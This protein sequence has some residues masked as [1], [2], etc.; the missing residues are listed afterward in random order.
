MI[1]VLIII[2]MILF[3]CII[4]NYT[5][6]ASVQGV[7]KKVTYVHPWIKVEQ[8][9]LV[10][11]EVERK[12]AEDNAYTVARQQQAEAEGLAKEA[13]NA[14]AARLQEVSESNEADSSYSSGGAG[15][16]D[17]VGEWR[18]VVVPKEQQLARD[19]WGSQEQANAL[20]NLLDNENYSRDP[21][22][23][24]CGYGI[25]QKIDGWDDSYREGDV[26]GQLAWV[27]NYI[28][29]SSQGYGDAI[30]AWSHKQRCGWY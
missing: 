1:L 25:G 10:K 11:E 26:D 17:L 5:K 14:E 23:V 18:S 7:E 19:R 28:C 6:T 24:G 4:Y 20:T 12:V 3:S 27:V 16:S 29:Y 15:S 9:L 22:L 8:E 21:F 2:F 13:A 30:T